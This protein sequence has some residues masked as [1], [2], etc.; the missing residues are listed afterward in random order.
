MLKAIH[1]HFCARW[2][3]EY[4]KELQKRHKWKSPEINVTENTLVVVREENLPPNCWR[5]GRVTK[6][7]HGSDNRVR[8]ADVRTQRGVITRPIT[9]L[10]I[11]SDNIP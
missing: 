10:V 7:Y 8:V 9:K 4:L 2:K 5:L 11:I 6:V 1:Q 3:N